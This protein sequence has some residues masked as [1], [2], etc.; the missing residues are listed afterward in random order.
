MEFKNLFERFN[1]NGELALSD[2]L[3]S[4]RFGELC[5]S[6]HPDFDGVFLKHI[7]PPSKQMVCLVIIW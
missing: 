7:I 1:Q 2:K 6:E 5:F 4:T 3:F